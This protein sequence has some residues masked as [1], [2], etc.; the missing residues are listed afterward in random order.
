MRRANV[1]RSHTDPLRIEPDG[2]KVGKH[3][4]EPKR[5]V[6]SDVLAEEEGRVGLLQDAVDLGPEVALVVGSAAVA[7]DAER[8]AGVASNDEIHA[9]TPRCA[10][11]GAEIVEDRSRIQRRL[12]HPFHEAGCCESVPLDQTH[13]S[14]PGR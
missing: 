2:G 6:S 3:V 13:G 8:L 12:R 7:G 11:E 1:G 5:K 14:T 4:G 9:S 10:I